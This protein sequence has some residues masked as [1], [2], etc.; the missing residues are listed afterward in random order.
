[1]KKILILDDDIVLRTALKSY[2]TKRNYTVEEAGAGEYA[3]KKFDIFRPDLIVSDVVMPDMDGFTFCRQVR[4]RSDGRLIPFIFLSARGN[5]E[6][7]IKG[8]VMGADAYLT[9]PIKLEELTLQIQFQLS[10]VERINAEIVR[11]LQKGGVSANFNSEPSISEPS[12]HE[13]SNDTPPEPLPLTPA[14]ER[15]FT[16][17]IQGFTNKQISQ[18]LHISPRTVQTHLSNILSKLGVENRT[19]LTHLAYE[20][21]YKF[22]PSSR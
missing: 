3:L 7:Q 21:G 22:E 1:M 19:Q 10:R 20:K 5:L 14:E 18:Q 17:V 16:E 12:P 8:H 11:L 6:D 15:V 2:L 13:L 4:S 9:K